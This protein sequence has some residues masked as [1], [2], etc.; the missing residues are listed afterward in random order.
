MRERHA[1]K[2]HLPWN[3]AGSVFTCTVFNLEGNVKQMQIFSELLDLVELLKLRIL[4]CVA[5]AVAVTILSLLWFNISAV[6][7]AR[8][9]V[10]SHF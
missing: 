6:L 5:V 1:L 9:T 10:L 2:S 8:L 7:L 3:S 4:C